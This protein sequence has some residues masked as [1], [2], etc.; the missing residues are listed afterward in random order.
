MTK[1]KLD[2]RK[3]MGTTDEGR[4]T[5]PAMRSP[6]PKAIFDAEKV[7]GTSTAGKTVGSAKAGVQPK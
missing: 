5:G 4:Q 7:L 2:M 6:K 3:V 1:L